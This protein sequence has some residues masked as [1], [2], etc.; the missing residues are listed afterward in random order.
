MAADSKQAADE[1]VVADSQQVAKG[2]QQATGSSGPGGHATWEPRVPTRS[3]SCAVM[4]GISTHSWDARSVVGCALGYLVRRLVFHRHCPPQL[5]LLLDHVLGLN[6]LIVLHLLAGRRSV[7]DIRGPR[8]FGLRL[9][10][11]L[12]E[13]LLLPLRIPRLLLGVLLGVPLQFL[14]LFD[15]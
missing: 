12:L 14:R 13:R 9:L 2:R 3:V 7:E 10:L 11:D 5:G 8:L 15:S 4:S 6:L 1:H